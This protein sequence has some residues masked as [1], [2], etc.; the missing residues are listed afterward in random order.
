VNLEGDPIKLLE[1]GVELSAALIE[2]DAKHM[3]E[4]QATA[5]MRKVIPLLMKVNKCPDFI[6]D[7]GHMFGTQLPLPDKRA[8]IE[9]LKTF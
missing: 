5:R 7:K 4:Q 3:N 9:L 1:L 6:E 2:I 8:L